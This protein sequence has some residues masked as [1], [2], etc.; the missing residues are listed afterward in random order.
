LAKGELKSPQV[1]AY[2]DRQ[3]IG[4]CLVDEGA[5]VNVML[6]WL[7]D[8]LG[9]QVTQSTSLKLKVVDQRCVKSLG[10][11]AKIPITVNGVTV[12]VDFHVLNISETRGGYPL[13]LGRPWLKAVRAVNYW[14]KGNMR[15]GPHQHRVSIQVIPDAEEGTKRV[16]SPE[17]SS[18]EE[19][20]SWTSEC[21]T[22]ESSS[23]SEADLFA[24]ESL[25]QVVT[26]SMEHLEDETAT[27][28]RLE[29][30]LQLIKFGPSL[31]NIEKDAF[32]SLVI[33][34]AEI[35]VTRHQDLPSV[36][37]EEHTIDS[38]DG[39]KPIREKQRRMAPDKSAF[40]KAEL[41]RLLEGGFIT[42]VKNTEW[43]SPVVIVPKKGGK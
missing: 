9:I 41:D 3:R 1:E 39:F 22:T 13:I 15:I 36:I 12:D 33:E 2:I 11:I 24:L 37:L 31:T 14:E 10:L 27:L 18:D 23:D 40:L 30:T 35:F 25:P 42:Q 8:D 43:V 34:F 19:Y 7:M 5:A 20:D 38:K 16:S 6:N 17:D 21:T 32:Q 4:G 26:Q 29:D 28:T